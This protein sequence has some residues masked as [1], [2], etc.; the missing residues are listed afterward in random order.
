MI[1]AIWWMLW[2]MA[3]P[4]GIFHSQDTSKNGN[5]AGAPD[6]PH[7]KLKLLITSLLSII[8][9]GIWSYIPWIDW[10]LESG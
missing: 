3:L 1:S 2:F 9:W 6:N 5:D 7:I 8:L 10:I 4:F